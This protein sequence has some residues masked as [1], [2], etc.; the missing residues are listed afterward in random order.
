VEAAGSGHDQGPVKVEREAGSG[1]SRS[2]WKKVR[3]LAASTTA[4]SFE[5]QRLL[6]TQ[7][8]G[9]RWGGK[10]YIS[11]YIQWQTWVNTKQLCGESQISAPQKPQKHLEP[12]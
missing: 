2:R 11:P 6:S 10:E 9:F 8:K 4:L 1:R 5:V 7:G 12:C 3:T